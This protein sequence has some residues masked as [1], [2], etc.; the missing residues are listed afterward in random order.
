MAM[1]KPIRLPGAF[2]ALFLLAAG[3]LSLPI[4]PVLSQEQ[5]HRFEYFGVEHGL[6]SGQILCIYEDKMGFL[7]FGTMKGLVRYDGYNFKLHRPVPEDS[8]SLSNPVVINI[9][10]DLYGNLW[11]GTHKG[12]NRYD[13][14]LLHGNNGIYA[15]DPNSIKLDTVRPKVV[16]TDFK[17][18]DHSEDL[19]RAPELADSITIQFADQIITFEFAAL[20]F[21]NQEHIRYKYRLEGFHEQWLDNG[22]DRKVSFTNLRPGRYT[23]RVQACNADGF[24]SGEKE[25]L[26]VRLL[27]LPPL[28]GTWWA[29]LIYLFLIFCIVQAVFRFRLR[30][31]LAIDEALRLKEL[32]RFKTRLY[33]N[34]THEFRTP[35]TL[36]LGP[37]AG[38]LQKKQAADQRGVEGSPKK[39]RASP[40]IGESDTRSQQAGCRR[41]R[42]PLRAGR[43]HSLYSLSD[44]VVSQFCSK[45]WRHAEIF[46]RR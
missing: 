13:R 36:I 45:P 4:S 24:C 26:A 22:N 39:L 31:K 41:S 38:S 23:F 1:R 7:W 5:Q 34:I 15:F 25:E 12:L 21:L 11:I 44:Q 43:R 32:D 9:Q 29:I 19:G 33:T 17:I 3:F 14:I 6:P 30:Q 10:E 42:R 8:S 46:F 35:L 18:L 28:W 2:P 27:V 37:I 40:A 20:H 16:L